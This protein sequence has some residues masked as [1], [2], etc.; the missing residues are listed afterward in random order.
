MADPIST[1]T[2]GT[3][4]ASIQPDVAFN[5]ETTVSC[6]INGQPVNAAIVTAVATNPGRG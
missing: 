4:T 3:C 2:I 5:A 6:T 1:R